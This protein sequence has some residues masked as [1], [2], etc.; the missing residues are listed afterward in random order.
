MANKSIFIKT[1]RGTIVNVAMK[2]GDVK[3]KL[4]WNDGFGTK[5]TDDFCRAQKFV[6]SEV[7]RLSAPYVP[8]DTGMLQKSGTLGTVI[9]NGEVNWIA[10]YA[11]AQYYTT[12]QTRSYDA[13]RGGM[14]FERMKADHKSAIIAGAKKIA[15]G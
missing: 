13:L 5:R 6:D 3:A 14:W 2:N 4:T 11:A 12:A 8:F 10:P 15:G 7:L 1:P 9:G